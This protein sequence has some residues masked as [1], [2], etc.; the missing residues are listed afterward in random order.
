MHL[1]KLIDEDVYKLYNIEIKCLF[2]NHRS[3]TRIALLYDVK[4]IILL[5]YQSKKEFVADQSKHTL[6]FQ[7]PRIMKVSIL[8]VCVM[9]LE[10]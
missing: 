8:L 7:R 10:G 6:R 9:M 3:N 1:S 5:L 4:I 2:T